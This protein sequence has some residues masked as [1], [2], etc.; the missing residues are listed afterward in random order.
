[1]MRAQ[2]VARIF[3]G[4]A[5]TITVGVAINQVLNNNKISW[6]WSLAALCVTVL[7]AVYGEVLS[8]QAAASRSSRTDAEPRR[9]RRAYLR[10]LRASVANME[11]LGIATQSEYALRMQQVYVDVSLMPQPRHLTADEPYLGQV[12]PAPPE[13]QTL[14]SFL[15]ADA[16]QVIAVIGGPGSGKTTLV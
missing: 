1:M 11:T 9:I 13:R 12:F 5:A 4:A 16:S 14:S 6:N 15:G 2:Q 7:S 8:P 10:Q 3:T